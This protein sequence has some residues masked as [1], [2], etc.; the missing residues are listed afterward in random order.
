[1]TGM[2]TPDMKSGSFRYRAKFGEGRKNIN[3]LADDQVD[4][5]RKVV[6]FVQAEMGSNA[7]RM[8]FGKITLPSVWRLDALH[9]IDKGILDY[10]YFD[11]RGRVL[12]RP[13]IDAELEASLAR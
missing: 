7:A 5:A 2:A 10:W 13:N 6:Q 3:V 4:A 12:L 11:D 9:P 8:S 1:M